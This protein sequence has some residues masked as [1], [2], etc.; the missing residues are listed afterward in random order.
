MLF[1]GTDS[2]V[3][4]IK[5]DD[6]HED[7]YENRSLFDFSDCPI[8]SR[9]YD[10]GNKKVIGEMKDE[11]RG[12]IISEFVGLKSK[13]YSL[14]MVDNEE[15]E[16]EKAVNKNVIKNIR[17]KE[18]VYVLF[19]RGLVRHKMKRVQSRLHRIGTYDACKISLSCF[20]NKCYI[21]N[22]GVSSLAYF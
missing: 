2:L 6:V 7:F 14:V 1:T 18:Y 16:K 4:E 21:L 19:D 3:Y 13:M 5:V 12:K 15:I 9:F 22:D 10:P 8:D 17:H 11:V 20:D